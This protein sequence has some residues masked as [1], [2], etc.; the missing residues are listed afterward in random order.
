MLLA[1]D[2]AGLCA[3]TETNRVEEQ[4][5]VLWVIRNRVESPRFPNTYEGVIL[6]PKQFSAFNPYTT[7]AVRSHWP[8]EMRQAYAER[9]FDDVSGYRCRLLLASVHLAEK[10]LNLP[11]HPPRQEETL[12]PDNGLSSDVLHYYSPVSMEPPGS[13]PAWAKSAKRLFTPA[14]IN[15]RRFV[16]AEGVS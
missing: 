13:A 7:G 5:C 11:R 3:L 14:G 2:W 9:V 16:F 6:Q 8:P 10:V 4:E 15:P 12:E 1:V